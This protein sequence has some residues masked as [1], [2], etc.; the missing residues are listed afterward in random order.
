MSDHAP[1][2]YIDDSMVSSVTAVI[3]TYKDKYIYPDSQMDV[4]KLYLKNHSRGKRLAKEY[5]NAF[6][7]Y[8]KALAEKEAQNRALLEQEQKA[9]EAQSENLSDAG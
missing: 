6:A 8:E 4:A 3:N 9:L 7:A 1:N 5:R 2:A